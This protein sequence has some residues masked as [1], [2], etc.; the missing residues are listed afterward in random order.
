M[1]Y[2]LVILL[3]V[4][5]SCFASA[6]ADEHNVQY[7]DIDK[8][9]IAY[10]CKGS[11]DLTV[12]LIAGMGLD[13]H[14]TYKNTFHN[15]NAS[16]YR[17]CMYDRA[18]TG[19]STKFSKDVRPIGDLQAE[20]SALKQHA[21][22]KD[23]LL[24]AHSFGGFVARAYTNANPSKVKGMI[25]V[26]SAH[27]SWYEDMKSSMSDDAWGTME[28]IMEW[29]KSKHSFEDFEEA[30]SQS[31]IYKIPQHIPVTVMSRGI[32]HVSIRQ[33]K[34]SYGDVDAYT[35]T[36][37]RSQ[38]ALASISPISKRVTMEY[39]SHFFDE[40]DPWIVIKEIEAMISSLDSKPNK[41][42]QV[43]H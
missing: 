1:R 21:G 17:I 42:Q 8:N 36:W 4:S 24:V 18:G 2:I 3:F 30:S 35:D 37:N 31:D 16:G 43:A 7:F 19:K 11:G 5:F 28:W 20:L 39:A 33:T 14:S 22:W 40:T 41:H 15:L 9:R 38:Y 27:E 26:D 13:V 6:S 29:E 12:L 32:P 25:F 10:A 23:L 34:M